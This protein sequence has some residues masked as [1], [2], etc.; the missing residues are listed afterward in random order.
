MT[1]NGDAKKNYPRIPEK[2]W[3]QLR[4]QFLKTVPKTVTPNY[5][6]SALGIQE[7]T[8]KNYL[9]PMKRLGLIDENGS[10]TELAQKWRHD[11]DYPRVCSEMRKSV[12]PQELRDLQDGQ[13]AEQNTTAGWFL[14]ELKVGKAAAE[15]M[16]RLYVLLCKGD[17]SVQDSLNA[18]KEVA[19]KIKSPTPAG[20]RKAKAARTRGNIT[21]TE[22][23]TAHE[24]PTRQAH[25]LSTKAGGGPSLHVDIQV[26]I[27][28]E[29]SAEQVDTIFSSMAKHL[30]QRKL[31]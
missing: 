19:K 17:P 23:A 8:A 11:Q 27:S 31:D 22:V 26:H 25:D 15:Q 28:P 9:A 3:W 2:V 1:M 20:E 12:Y 29:A 30:F 10:P 14:R 7:A 5:L 16:A 13:D 6:A 4:K 24:S 18:S 21:S